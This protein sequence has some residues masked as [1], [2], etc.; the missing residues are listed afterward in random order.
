MQIKE[1]FQHSD[2]RILGDS[3]RSQG[4]CHYN[5]NLRKEIDQFLYLRRGHVV[6]VTQYITFKHDGVVWIDI[7]KYSI[8]PCGRPD[9]GDFE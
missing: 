2:I 9:D 5:L 1:A 7:R 3:V 4:G 8:Y 6:R